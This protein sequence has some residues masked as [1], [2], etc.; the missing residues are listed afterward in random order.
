MIVPIGFGKMNG[1]SNI[2]IRNSGDAGSAVEVL[3]ATEPGF[4]AKV[5][6]YDLYTG[7]DI[8]GSGGTSGSGPDP[9]GL[10]PRYSWVE[11]IELP[12][13]QWMDDPYGREGDPSDGSL[14][15]A[16]EANEFVVP[17]GSVVWMRR[18]APF[19]KAVYSGS[20]SHGQVGTNSGYDYRF[21]YEAGEQIS[22][23]DASGSGPL[24]VTRTW[25]VTCA[26]GSVSTITVTDCEQLPIATRKL[27]DGSVRMTEDGT[28]RTLES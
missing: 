21:A 2:E 7:Q 19:D 10:R 28:T 22:G 27:D 12:E 4:W 18:G 20:G 6:F 8:S 17:D 11:Q 23:S 9:T 14:S 24:C 25:T 1:H 15:P 5:Y 13:G 26:D 16:F 3:Y